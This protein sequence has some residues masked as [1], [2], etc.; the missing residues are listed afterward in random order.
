MESNN[1]SDFETNID[2]F[3]KSNLFKHQKKSENSKETL[4]Q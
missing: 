4:S 2:I 3:L 1:N